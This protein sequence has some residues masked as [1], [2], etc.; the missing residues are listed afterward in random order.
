MNQSVFI[1]HRK[2]ILDLM[3]NQSI[4]M[5]WSTPKID[6]KKDVDRNYYYV[7]GNFEYENIVVLVKD[8]AVTKE[9]MFINP[10]DEKKAKWV[11]AP[12]SKEK[13]SKQN[14]IQEIYYL[15]EFDTIVEPYLNQLTKLYVDLKDEAN[16]YSHEKLY[17]AEAKKKYPHLVIMNANS[18][19]K[20]ARTVKLPEEIAE[21]QKAIA[22]TKKG[23]E[24]ILDHM[25]ECYEYQLESYFDQAIKYEGGTGYAFPTIAAS[26]KNGCC[27]H[28]TANE[29]IAH[30]GDL[31]LFDLG[32]SYDMYCA[33]ISRTFPVNGKFSARQKQIYE[34]VLNGQAEVMKHIKPGITTKELNQILV[35]YYEKELLAIGLISKPEEIF[36][37][38]YHGV[39]H[40]I[41]LECHD[42]CDYTPLVP[43]TIISCEPGL[44]I[45]EEK[46]GIRIEDD[47]LVT[48][49]GCINLSQDILKTVDEIEEYMKGRKR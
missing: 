24:N 16:D 12:L 19:F 2:T 46:I 44:Y 1:K 14:G 28:Y 10:Y 9:M 41:G 17:A 43:N 11:G 20:T 13:V 49:D 32:A 26:G 31:I 4:L 29:D 27:L 21:M 42:L 40:H 7:S 8:N 15:S 6:V 37:Y 25:Q 5:V 38:Y 18:L 36:K 22:I 48:E 30:D 33:D 23:I 3:M 34:I 35:R 45:D 39:S 47:I